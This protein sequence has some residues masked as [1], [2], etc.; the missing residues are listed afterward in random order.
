MGGAPH[1]TGQSLPG[2]PPDAVG[3]LADVQR[4][5]TPSDRNPLTIT[6]QIG[7]QQFSVPAPQ[8][9]SSRLENK[10][11]T[12]ALS[13]LENVALT[14]P[15]DTTWSVT[16]WGLQAEL[17]CDLQGISRVTCDFVRGELVGA[18]LFGVLP[19]AGSESL[20]VT[21][22][23]RQNTLT[24]S[25][26]AAQLIPFLAEH[27]LTEP[28]GAAL[29]TIQMDGESVRIPGWRSSPPSLWLGLLHAKLR[30]S[31][32]FVSGKIPPS[33]SL[34]LFGSELFGAKCRPNYGY[35]AHFAHGASQSPAT[36]AFYSPGDSE[37]CEEIIRLSDRALL[38]TDLSIGQ[39]LELLAKEPHFEQRGKEV[40]FVADIFE[41]R[42]KATSKGQTRYDS[43]LSF[44]L[45]RAE[46]LTISGEFPSSGKF[47]IFGFCSE[48]PAWGGHAHQ[49]RYRRGELEEVTIFAKHAQDESGH[50][51][52]L[53]SFNASEPTKLRPTS[54]TTP[55]L[56]KELPQASGTAAREQVTLTIENTS[57]TFVPPPHRSAYYTLL[58]DRM[59]ALDRVSIEKSSSDGSIYFGG[60]SYQLNFQYAE[61]ADRLFSRVT[62]E[63]GKAIA[64]AILGEDRR[65]I[66]ERDIASH[67]RWSSSL[68]MAELVSL[69]QR[70]PDYHTRET[71]LT[72]E[73]ANE[74]FNV[75]IPSTGST[76]FEEILADRIHSIPECKV[77]RL[78][79]PAG[80]FYGLGISRMFPEQ[81]KT[82]KWVFI[83]HG[84]VMAA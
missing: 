21:Y 23:A 32:F 42:T 84:Q 1:D 45:R 15:C 34:G 43:I 18:S 50:P 51:K 33:G 6:I 24:S 52:I 62:F 82:F 30:S 54:L 65:I 19:G 80:C 7:D 37:R 76:I 28:H 55:E 57:L 2:T 53:T 58:I 17:P 22:N 4:R 27:K 20:I 40:T 13:G 63:N 10:Q 79:T 29:Q 71:V 36:V 9:G 3:L 26:E 48:F 38:G 47:Q 12:A 75:R 68:P 64:I 41:Y 83:R 25:L 69:L 70:M 73:V 31:A 35:V 81:A 49:L 78:L 77:G 16:A 72:I 56:V 5:A 67:G 60:L 46:D 59:K 14:F 61:V 44:L 74:T 8:G 66:A 39:C 11:L